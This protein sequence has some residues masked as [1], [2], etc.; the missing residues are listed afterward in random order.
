MSPLTQYR[1]RLIG[2]LVTGFLFGLTVLYVHEGFVLLFFGNVFFWSYAL[3]QVRCSHCDAQ[4][5]PAIGASFAEVSR[6][7]QSK[8]CRVCGTQIDI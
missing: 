2:F 1:S 5:A 6:S 8:V 7:F 4:L 3:R